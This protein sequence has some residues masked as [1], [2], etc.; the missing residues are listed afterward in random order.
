[1]SSLSFSREQ[2]S[3]LSPK[4]AIDDTDNYVSDDIAGHLLAWALKRL[5]L[6]TLTVLPYQAAQLAA[7][8]VQA[9]S[10]WA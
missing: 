1:M 4:A 5:I 10:C 2:S 7:L 9:E 6:K 3:G 8:L